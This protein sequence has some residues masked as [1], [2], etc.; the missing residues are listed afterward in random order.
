MTNPLNAYK[1]AFAQSSY[2]CWNQ[3]FLSMLYSSTLKGTVHPN[4]QKDILT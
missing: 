2:D 4:M 3:R 1:S